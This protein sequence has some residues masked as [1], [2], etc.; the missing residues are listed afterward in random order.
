VVKIDILQIATS[1]LFWYLHV[2]LEHK[3]IKCN[4]K[5]T[6]VASVSALSSIVWCGNGEPK[7]CRSHIKEALT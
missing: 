6:F 2:D 7:Q 1:W 4:V 5:S 3:E